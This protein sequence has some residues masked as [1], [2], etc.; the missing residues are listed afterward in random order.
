MSKN[1]E[2]LVKENKKKVANKNSEPKFLEYFSLNP[3]KC[4]IVVENIN[5]EIYKFLEQHNANYEILSLHWS[6]RSVSLVISENFKLELKLQ[7][8]DYA[9]NWVKSVRLTQR[10]L[11]FPL[12]QKLINDD[13]VF[14]IREGQK[15][16]D[17]SKDVD[18]A[19][20]ALSKLTEDDYKK[21]VE[22]WIRKVL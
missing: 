17:P 9:S 19:L 18:K 11:R 5:K 8:T 12:W 21:I 20:E 6:E 2:E 3:N 10:N 14:E 15:I 16:L 4:G 7:T 1:I 13:V 22:K